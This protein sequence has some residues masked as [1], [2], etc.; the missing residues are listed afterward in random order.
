MSNV[1]EMR[2]RL[3][4]E[5]LE[6]I[7]RQESTTLPDRNG[8]ILLRLTGATLALLEF[9]TIDDKGRCRVRRCAWARWVPWRTRRI[10][11]VFATV[12]FWMEQPLWIVQKTG[13]KQ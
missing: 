8:E 7:Y 10:C 11:P 4:Q 2:W 12:H 9:H 5:R 13:R 3:L 1:D 6:K